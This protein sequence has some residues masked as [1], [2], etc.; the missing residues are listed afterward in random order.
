MIL[1][2]LIK[3]NFYQGISKFSCINK[4]IFFPRFSLN[5]LLNKGSLPDEHRS[6]CYGG[7]FWESEFHSEVDSQGDRDGV[8]K[9][10]SFIQGWDKC[11]SLGELNLKDDWLVVTQSFLSH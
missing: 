3:S 9:Y 2:Q 11:E 4:Y 10:I 1:S 6:Q 7:N 8:L 5:V